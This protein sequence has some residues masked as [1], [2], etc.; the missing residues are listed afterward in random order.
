MDTPLLEGLGRA[1]E[2]AGTLASTQ[3]SFHPGPQGR[4]ERGPEEGLLTRPSRWEL[5]AKAP[6]TLDPISSPQCLPLPH[7]M[8]TRRPREWVWPEGRHF[9]GCFG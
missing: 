2:P 5:G 8:L 1:E 7:P 4:G 9:V 6:G 3:R